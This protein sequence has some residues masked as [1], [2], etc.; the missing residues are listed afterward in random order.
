M[1]QGQDPPVLG[2]HP[3][4]AVSVY[5]GFSSY[6]R[7]PTQKHTIPS[8]SFGAGDPWQTRG[9]DFSIGCYGLRAGRTWWGEKA[10]LLPFLVLASSDRENPSPPL[11]PTPTQ[12]WDPQAL[13]RHR[14]VGGQVSST[15]KAEALASLWA[16]RPP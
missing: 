3:G 12:I 7:P 1:G 16:S 14:G 4:T 6:S 13:G 15:V 9:K 2:S 8:V 10:T 5:N 11:A